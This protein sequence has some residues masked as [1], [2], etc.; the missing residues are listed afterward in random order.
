MKNSTKIKL[1]I[2]E[3][4]R[5]W[6][7]DIALPSLALQHT[8]YEIKQ[9]QEWSSMALVPVTDD[10]NTLN[11]AHG[12]GQMAVREPHDDI[13]VVNTSCSV[14]DPIIPNDDNAPNPSQ[15]DNRFPYRYFDLNKLGIDQEKQ[16]F[17]AQYML[18]KLA[19]RAENEVERMSFIFSVDSVINNTHPISLCRMVDVVILCIALGK[20]SLKS[21]QRTV[22]IIGKD[23]I[24]GS[25]ILRPSKS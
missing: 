15:Q 25:I 13:W 22:E 23:R 11:V 24:L 10:V 6:R 1:H 9:K 17:T 19:E 14:G 18:D 5:N 20:T 4:A 3:R 21:V 2:P 12:I 7:T 8:W 16:I